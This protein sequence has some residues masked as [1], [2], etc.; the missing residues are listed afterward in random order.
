[1]N[2]ELTAENKPVYGVLDSGSSIE[3]GSWA[4]HKDKRRVE[5]LVVL[6]RVI[7][8]KLCRFPPVHSEEVGP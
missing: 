1:M 3:G 6:I 2:A 8:V 7:P 4:T 5:I